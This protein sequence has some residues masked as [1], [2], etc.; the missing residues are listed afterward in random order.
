MATNARWAEAQR[1]ERGFWEGLARRIETGAR[2]QLD[3]YGWKARELEKRVFRWMGESD[4]AK[5]KVLEIGSGPIGIVSGLNWGERFAVD[6]LEGFYKNRDSL[7]AL[8]NPSVKFLEGVG[9]D[10]PFDD[11]MF[12]LA[13]VDNVIDHTR[14]PSR[15]LE[16][17]HRVL[18][19]GG[20]MYLAVNV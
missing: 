20:Y 19:S 9:E 6:P 7:V 13:I 17:V 15:I 2:G 3:W 10:L 8:R 1:Y 14:S 11:G 18:K 16:E 4:R 5:A 12:S